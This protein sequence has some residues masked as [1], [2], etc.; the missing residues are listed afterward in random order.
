MKKFDII[1]LSIAIAFIVLWI[2]LDDVVELRS[3][4]WLI[5]K[6]SCIFLLTITPIVYRIIVEKY[7]IM[8]ILIGILYF[9]VMLLNGWQMAKRD[10]DKYKNN[11]CQDKFGMTF[12]ARRLTRGIPVIPA[13]WHNT[14]SYGFFEADWKPKNKVTGHGE[15]LIFFTNDYGVEFER[16]D[17]TINP[18]QGFPMAISILTKFAKRKGKDT[19]SFLYSLGDST[20][21]IT[22]TQADSIFAAEKIAKDY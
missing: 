17:Y 13:G 6:Y 22:R 19:I 2:Y 14:S 1:F 7:P 5:V 3:L 4:N 16:D 9:G 18:K 21:T 11:I 10:I 12:N 15:K 20:H 8:G